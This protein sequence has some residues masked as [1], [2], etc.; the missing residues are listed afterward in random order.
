MDA[1]ALHH[2]VRSQ[3]F[4]VELE[5]KER[6]REF[7]DKIK[8]INYD[9]VLAILD[10]VLTDISIPDQT[11]QIDSI[12]LD[13][14]KVD[15]DNF[16]YELGLRFE[17]ALLEY[18]KG[19]F[20][21]NGRLKVGRTITQATGRLGQ[22]ESFLTTG[23]FDWN[24]EKTTHPT[25]LAKEMLKKNPEGLATL[26]ENE[27]SNEEV[28]KR[29]IF[30]F[31]DQILSDFVLVSKGSFGEQILGYRKEIRKD[32]QK[33][34]RVNASEDK[35]RI[36]LWDITLAYIYLKTNSYHGRKQFLTF[37]FRKV[38]DKY[39]IDYQNLLHTIQTGVQK[40]SEKNVRRSR[41]CGNC[42]RATS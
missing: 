38:A 18:F 20:A 7:F 36:A 26:L 33:H 25:D 12:E 21:P 42:R 37:Y 40:F 1:D 17:E 24:A 9:K 22:F 4:N 28:R 23:H 10:D 13:L 16:E 31:D 6:S 41:F 11:F 39:S 5:D 3:V 2:I 27:A 14:G 34:Q 35:F 15:F 19:A 30:Q 29:L 8:T 32:Q